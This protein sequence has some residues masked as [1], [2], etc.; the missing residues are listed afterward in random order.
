VS[1]APVVQRDVPVPVEYTG[2]LAANV[3]ADARARVQGILLEQRYAEGSAGR[4]GQ[5]LFVIDPKPYQAAKLQAE[6]AL[7]QTAPTR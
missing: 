1:V 6:G 3:N 2:T 5:L 7:A 4:A